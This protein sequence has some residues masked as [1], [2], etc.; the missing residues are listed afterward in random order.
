MRIIT[1][2]KTNGSG[3]SQVVAKAAGSQKTTTFDPERSTDWNHGTAAGALIL[4]MHAKAPQTTNSA[5]EFVRSLD[6]GY[7]TH[8]S[9]DDGVRHVF[10]I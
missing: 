6:A 5:R 4:S 8:E 10:D 7:G 1:T 2:Y 3:R 9:S